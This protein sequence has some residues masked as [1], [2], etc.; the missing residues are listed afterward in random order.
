MGKVE[1][2]LDEVFKGF[3]HDP[4]FKNKGKVVW[5]SGKSLIQFKLDSTSICKIWPCLELST[6]PQTSLNGRKVR[7]NSKP[8]VWASLFV[9]EFTVF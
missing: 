7:Q 9:G 5:K 4:S 8:S 3:R 2:K 1:Q 6:K